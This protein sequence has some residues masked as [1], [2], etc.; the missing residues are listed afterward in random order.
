VNGTVIGEWQA[1][2]V[3]IQEANPRIE[4]QSASI[5]ASSPPSVRIQMRKQKLRSL[6]IALHRSPLQ[7]ICLVQSECAAAEPAQVRPD[8]WSLQRSAKICG[9][10]AL[11]S[12]MLAV[13]NDCNDCNDCN[14]LD[15]SDDIPQ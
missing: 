14:D 7:P 11:G 8:E 10:A 4:Q 13:A 9:E 15:Y 5:E 12:K 2:A 3:K 1:L 6:S